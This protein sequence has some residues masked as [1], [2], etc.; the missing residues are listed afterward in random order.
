ML[1]IHPLHGII[2][3]TTKHTTPANTNRNSKFTLRRHATNRTTHVGSLV[4]R[5]FRLRPKHDEF[6]PALGTPPRHTVIGAL[7]VH[8]AIAEGIPEALD[9]VCAHVR[10]ADHVDERGRQREPFFEVVNAQEAESVD[11]GER[12]RGLF[13]ERDG[14]AHVFVGVA[15][16]G[17]G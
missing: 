14:F 10:V 15:L 8:L 4:R 6:A 12:E 7:N 13:R 1:C 17:L 2:Y 9:A 5:V 11:E 3:R 16:C